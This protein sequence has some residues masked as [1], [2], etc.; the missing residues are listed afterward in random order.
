MSDRAD[1]SLIHRNPIRVFK[2]AVSIQI[3]RD[4]DGLRSLWA[5]KFLQVQNRLR[6]LFR[7]KPGLFLR[8]RERPLRGLSKQPRV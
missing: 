6:E 3:K 7:C 1:F 8:E 2:G 5:L 4:R